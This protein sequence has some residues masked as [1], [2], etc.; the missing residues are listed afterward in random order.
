MIN[1]KGFT[2]L[3]MM[4]V[5]AI[6]AI[7]VAISTPIY[8]GFITKSKRSAAS[9]CLMES[10]HFLER[11]YTL[12]MRY[13]QTSSGE[14]IA[15]SNSSCKNS[16]SSDYQISIVSIDETTYTIQAQPI[17]LQASRDDECGTMTIDEIGTKTVSGS[18][19]VSRCW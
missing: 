19:A 2:L 11:N 18:A 5:V 3:E 8:Q 7:L 12:A 16:L 13:D 14:D 17:G 9:V 10:S 4:V 1:S 6:I 15:L